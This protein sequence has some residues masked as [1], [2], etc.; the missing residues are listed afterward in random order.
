MPCR[1]LLP[2]PRDSRFREHPAL[3]PSAPH[4]RVSY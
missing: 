2:P 3:S 1:Q 4:S